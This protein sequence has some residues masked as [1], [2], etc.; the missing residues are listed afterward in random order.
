MDSIPESATSDVQVSDTQQISYL[1]IYQKTYL[2]GIFLNV[3]KKLKGYLKM[4]LD[5]NSQ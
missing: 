2:K 4:I 5:I 3:F 1:Q